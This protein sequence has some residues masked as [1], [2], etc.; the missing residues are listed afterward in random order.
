V[1][2]YAAKQPFTVP[3][4]LA[5]TEEDE[6]EEGG[7]G[8]GGGGGGS[9]LSSSLAAQ[10][11]HHQ[12]HQQRQQQQAS[13]LAWHKSCKE[14]GRLVGTCSFPLHALNVGQC[15]VA[16]I[17]KLKKRSGLNV[18]ASLEFSVHVLL[19]SE[20]FRKSSGSNKPQGKSNGS[21]DDREEPLS[22][23]SEKS[24]P[25]SLLSPFSSGGVATKATRHMYP[26]DPVLKKDSTVCEAL[27]FLL[28]GAQ[29][30]TLVSGVTRETLK[31]QLEEVLKGFADDGDDE[32]RLQV[33]VQGQ[34][35]APSRTQAYLTFEALAKLFA[36]LKLGQGGI[37]VA[38]AAARPGVPAAAA[39]AAPGGGCSGGGGG[40]GGDAAAL[41]SSFSS[42]SLTSLSNGAV[43]SAR[44][45]SIFALTKGMSSGC[46]KAFIDGGHLPG[47]AAAAL[48]L[49]VKHRRK[50]TLKW[51]LS[52][53]HHPMYELFIDDSDSEHKRSGL[54]FRHFRHLKAELGRL[55]AAHFTAP[56]PPKFTKSSLGM[57]L[58]NE[59]LSQRFEGLSKW[60][61]DVDKHAEFLSNEQHA[62]F[63]DWLYQNTV[64]D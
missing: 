34:P 7:E 47:E 39:S 5:S 18:R 35:Q 54:R 30:L 29:G 50:L 37:V 31:K 17:A 12:Q 42:L 1:E 60:L 21:G 2:L 63:E 41:A 43:P 61:D 33:E 64:E 16:P 19:Q 24:S 27:L 9:G 6:E 58:S 4:S 36:A 22:E 62:A 14:V 40:G 10:Q 23:K 59:E 56:F 49:T 20:R 13:L 57:A 25:P 8:G 15:S 28:E 32:E 55:S 52:M 11:I 53:D 44:F 3:L 51:G 26:K 48:G 45:D 46:L 38:A